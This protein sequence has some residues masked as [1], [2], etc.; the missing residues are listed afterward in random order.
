MSNFKIWI[1]NPISGTNVVA[2]ETFEDEDQRKN[3]FRAG[4]GA[5]SIL[6]NTAL[7]QANLITCALMEAI[8]ETANELGVLSSLNDVKTVINNYFLNAS[9]RK[10]NFV[11]GSR[12]NISSNDT[13]SVVFGKISKYLSDLDNANAIGS[14]KSNLSQAAL[15]AYNEI[16]KGTLAARLGALENRAYFKIQMYNGE[17]VTAI[18]TSSPTKINALGTHT[19]NIPRDGI[20]EITS[21]IYCY[22]SAGNTTYFIAI[23]D[24]IVSGSG[25]PVLGQVEAVRPN[26]IFHELSAGSHTISFYASSSSTSRNFMLPPYYQSS[27]IIKEM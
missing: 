23:D 15:Y 3:G 4:T 27:V 5:S 9:L 24:N 20:Y 10:V 18:N 25:L 16:N 1:E 2:P 26:T 17:D 12:A 19:I 6:T 11:E 21:N 8:G 13:L 7:R 22:S 14:Q